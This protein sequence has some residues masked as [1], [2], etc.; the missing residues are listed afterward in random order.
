MRS[1]PPELQTFL[2]TPGSGTL[3]VRGGPGTGK[4][5]LALSTLSEFE[6]GRILVTTRV[7]QEELLRQFPWLLAESEGRAKLIEMVRLRGA[8]EA[9]PKRIEEMRR[10]LQTRGS[11]LV[12]LASVLSLPASVDE[13]LRAVDSGPRM[14]VIDSWEAWVENVLGTSS[15]DADAPVSR[16]ELERSLL[17]ALLRTG[18]KVLLVVERSEPTRFDYI[19][20]GTVVLSQEERDER[21][22]R[23]LTLVKLRGVRLTNTVYPFSLQDGRLVCLVPRVE[24]M[25]PSIGPAE[26]D[27]DPGAPSVWPGSSAFA[28]AFGRVPVEGGLLLE[29]DPDTPVAVVWTLIAPMVHAALRAGS[30]ILLRP[31]ENLAPDELWRGLSRMAPP[32]RLADLVRVAL[33]VS[34]AG[35]TLHQPVFVYPSPVPYG[36][37][38]SAGP[39]L[40]PMFGGGSWEAEFAQLDPLGFLRGNGSSPGYPLIVT[41]VD[42]VLDQ[43]H[44]G[45]SSDPFLQLPWLARR[46][47][48]A[49][50]NVVLLES[51][52]A[53][54]P[55][56][57][58]H[59]NAHLVL[60]TR[61]GQHF[62]YGIRPWSPR[63]ALSSAEESGA[64]AIPYDLT[65]IV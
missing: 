46:A 42:P 14:I 43:P 18:A 55:G 62:L 10:V 13:V 61:R 54:L 9:I 51:G 65:P 2:A 30:H 6:G 8:S 47:G 63:Y 41:F 26:L 60:R 37:E 36:G 48:I 49:P 21:T 15:F 11:D 5:T 25:V 20:D 59:A 31:P 27:P 23:W 32:E 4:T 38:Q 12:D 56:C 39:P 44:A 19:S 57:R 1:L 34:A 53:A 50:A 58:V 45:R 33:P 22:E 24:P 3:L 52:D 7:P 17:D 16:W 28:A 40:A 29:Y 64:S 35:G